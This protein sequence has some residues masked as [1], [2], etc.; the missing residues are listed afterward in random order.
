MRI[1]TAV[2]STRR[3]ESD[4]TKQQ[5]VGRMRT[6]L[7]EHYMTTLLSKRDQSKVYDAT[8]SHG[9][10]NHFMLTRRYVRFVD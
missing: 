6:A 7:A 10:N 1:L 9:V 5:V 8:S 4:H 3:S 2:F